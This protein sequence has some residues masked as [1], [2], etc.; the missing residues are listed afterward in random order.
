[1]KLAESRVFCGS[2]WLTEP[3]FDLDGSRPHG[4][5]RRR[6]AAADGRILA[7]RLAGQRWDAC[8]SPRR[9][10]RFSVR[11]RLLRMP[12]PLTGAATLRAGVPFARESWPTT[13]LA[14]LAEEAA[15][16]LQPL[17]DPKR[18]WVAARRAVVAGRRRGRTRGRPRSV[19]RE[20]PRQ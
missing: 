19:V 1:M 8:A 12:L 5:A 15:D 16:A 4:R 2:E 7:A 14:A 20:R 9:L 13:F 17:V 6:G 3:D 11:R 18:A 10:V